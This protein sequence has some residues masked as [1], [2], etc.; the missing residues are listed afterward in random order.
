ME[1]VFEGVSV[2]NAEALG[3]AEGEA[4]L[5]LVEAHV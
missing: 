3:G 2:E 1:G 4:T 5:V